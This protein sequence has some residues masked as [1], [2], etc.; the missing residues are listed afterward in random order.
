[1]NN[2]LTNTYRTL[3]VIIYCARTALIATAAVAIFFGVTAGILMTN[4]ELKAVGEFAL[5]CA[6]ASV[7]IELI[8]IKLVPNSTFFDL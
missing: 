5:W 1:M 2:I 7:I 4:S 6:I 8:R 3:C